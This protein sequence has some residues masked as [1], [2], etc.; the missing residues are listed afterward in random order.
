MCYFKKLGMK[1]VILL[2]GPGSGKGTIAGRLVSS[3]S[4][5]RHVSSGDLLRDAVKRQTPAGVEA[6]GFMKKGELVP[7][8]LIARMIAELMAGLTGGTTLLLDGFPRTL[9]QAKMLDETAGKCG[10]ALASV[11]LLDVA[12]AVLIDRIAGRRLCPKCGAGYHVTNIPPRKAGV[13]DVCGAELVTRKDDNLETVKNRL[14]VY[15][16]QTMPLID[17][18]GARGLLRKVEGTGALDGIVERV[19]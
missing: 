16:S 1:I 17:F 2:G 18:Y 12:D 3:D 11:V 4:S 10:A 8:A 15:K 13:C 7:D 9:A 6:D 5:F 14:S 19:R